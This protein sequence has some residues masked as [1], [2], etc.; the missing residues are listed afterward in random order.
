ML[1]KLIEIGVL[2]VVVNLSLP[3]ASLAAAVP[4]GFVRELSNFSFTEA[5]RVPFDIVK[6]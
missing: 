3:S 4:S 6:L 5:G 1:V 2:T